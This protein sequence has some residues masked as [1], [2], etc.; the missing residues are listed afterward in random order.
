MVIAALFI[1]IASLHTAVGDESRRTSWRAEV[2]APQT[3][4][5]RPA[6]AYTTSVRR[7][8]REA[9]FLSWHI[10][11]SLAS[12]DRLRVGEQDVD[13]MSNAGS[14]GEYRYI[15]RVVVSTNEVTIL[16]SFSAVSPLGGRPDDIVVRVR[17]TGAVRIDRAPSPD[18]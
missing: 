14:V 15:A 5:A 13:G 12:K 1:T 17:R 10:L 6:F 3:E 2:W 4:D 11:G 8:V 9:D 16:Y 7:R 18:A